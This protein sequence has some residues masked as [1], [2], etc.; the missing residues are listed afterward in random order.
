MN[1]GSSY[2]TL[3]ILFSALS[4]A[5]SDRANRGAGETPPSAGT[6]GRAAGHIGIEVRANG[7][8]KMK[9]AEPKPGKIIDDEDVLR[10]TAQLVGESPEFV[11]DVKDVPRLLSCLRFATRRD[12]DDLDFLAKLKPLYYLRILL[13]L[14]NSEYMLITVS[15]DVNG[16]LLF[17]INSRGYARTNDGKAYHRQDHVRLYGHPEFDYI[18]ESLA[19]KGEVSD[20][21]RRSLK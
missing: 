18:A 11:V 1:R 8:G 10:I 21:Y 9:L 13:F 16:P 7:A 19:L 3:F 5:R 6:G 4:C 12:E 15:V 2:L 17:T 14:K 20:M